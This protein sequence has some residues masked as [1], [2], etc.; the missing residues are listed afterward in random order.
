MSDTPTIAEAG[1][2]FRAR[3]LSP[4]ELLQHCMNQIERWDGELNSFL[5]IS[6]ER[7]LRDARAAER[8][9]LGGDALGPLDGI[10]IAHK[11]VIDTKGIPTTGHSRWLENNIPARD[12]EVVSQ[13]DAAG[14]VLLGKLATYE[15]AMGGPS[16][17]LPWPFPRNPWDVSRFAGG[18]SSGSGVAVAAG[19]VLGATGTDTG[20]SVRVPSAFCGVV[21]LKPTFGAISNAGLLPLAYSMD[22]IGPMAWTVHDCALLF[23]GMRGRGSAP[24]FTPANGD[25]KGC[26]IG[27][28][29]H[30][31][32]EDT[33]VSP[34]QISAINAAVGV[35]RDLGAVVEDVQLSSLLEYHAC[36]AL[37][38]CTEASAVHHDRIKSHPE[39]F[40]ERMRALLT[41][42]SLFTGVD[43]VQ[44]MRRRNELC[45][46]MAA[47]FAQYD[48]LITVGAAGE[49]PLL[50]E[51]PYWT[52]LSTPTYTIPFNVTGNPAMTVCCGFGSGGMPLGMQ[53]IGPPDG[54]SALFKIGHAYE[55]AADRRKRPLQGP[56][57]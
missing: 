35:F 41:I 34:D 29:R 19:L 10:P 44:A 14:S 24:D 57:I 27:V 3:K 11:D 31:F 45:R 1:A 39:K 16:D 22:H 55:Q 52:T 32:E 20:G 2:L 48:V 28:I 46:E 9:I 4:V 33:K 38:L 13:L 49:P 42:G 47:M 6:R 15:F 56:A 43:Y 17:D 8:R 7:A 54:E 18:S 26:R 23:D 40:G 12:A 5:H 30:F 53:I 37:I 36:G 21:G 50:A 51:V 25:L